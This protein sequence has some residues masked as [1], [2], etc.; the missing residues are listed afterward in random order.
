MKKAII[1]ITLVF[2]T[3]VSALA[4]KN[5]M[6]AFGAEGHGGMTDMRH[7]SGDN[8]AEWSKAYS[9]GGGLFLE[10]AFNDYF[11]FHTGV[12]YS[13]YLIKY[14]IP[15][16][17]RTSELSLDAIKV[18]MSFNLML[19]AN[20][21]SFVIPVGLSYTNIFRAY[22]SDKISTGSK[23]YDYIYSIEAN[24]FSAFS[25]LE[26]RFRTSAGFDFFIGG[27]GEYFITEIAASG[28][29]PS[30]DHIL[31]YYGKAGIILRTF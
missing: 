27:Y 7:E 29:S 17:D 4:A 3:S 21:V 6:I 26:L 8:S 15:D 24:Q 16:F 20:V 25:G 2:L 22:Q 30:E 10:K 9:Y 14:S 28:M 12:S 19:P 31:N 11:A 1:S 13:N 18:P 23:T 5:P